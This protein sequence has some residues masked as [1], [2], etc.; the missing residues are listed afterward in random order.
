MWEVF[1]NANDIS[2]FLMI[3]PCMS[4]HC[5]LQFQSNTKNGLLTLNCLHA[6]CRR[7][8][9]I[10]TRYM[11]TVYVH[12]IYHQ[13]VMFYGLHDSRVPVDEILKIRKVLVRYVYYL[14]FIFIQEKDFDQLAGQYAVSVQS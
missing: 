13:N 6:Q 11:Y 1:S 5:K 12:G 2:L 10:N 3:F 8:C 14:L 9:C 7:L 4:L